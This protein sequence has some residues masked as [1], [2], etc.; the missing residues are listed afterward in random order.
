MQRKSQK[1]GMSESALIRLLVSGYEPKAMPTDSFHEFM[2]RIADLADS[3]N[4][5]ARQANALGL[6]DA[7]YYKQQAE[8]L[9]QFELDVYEH[10]MLPDKA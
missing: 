5:I 6:L 10:F 8:Q 4:Q 3:M 1:A 7:A 2:S 9:Q